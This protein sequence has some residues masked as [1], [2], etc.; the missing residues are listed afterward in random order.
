MP[1]ASSILRGKTYLTPPITI[2]PESSV[3]DGARIMNEHRIGA[4]CVV[5][6]RKLLKGMFTERDILTRVVAEGRD[7]S[8]TLVRDVM[9]HPVIA[10]PPETSSDE[11]R[12]IMRQCRIRHIPIVEN[13][14]LLGVVSIGDLN[15]SQVKVMTETISY[16]ERY[17]YQP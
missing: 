7:P 12:K 16:L 4:L 1:T 8:T 10:C 2:T 15:M 11:L 6:D 9:T 3:L 13:N 17:M 14:S 5:T